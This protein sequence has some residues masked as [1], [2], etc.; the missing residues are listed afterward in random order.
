MVLPQQQDDAAMRAAGSSH[1]GGT[2][3]SM[4][5][6]S[7]ASRINNISF[8]AGIVESCIMTIGLSESLFSGA[9]LVAYV[10]NIGTGSE[11]FKWFRKKNCGVVNFG[12]I[13][14]P[15]WFKQSEQY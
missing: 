11:L 14:I 6:I 15:L 7:S 5:L 1:E 4:P 3:V 12:C 13:F 8:N 10:R 9:T 2:V